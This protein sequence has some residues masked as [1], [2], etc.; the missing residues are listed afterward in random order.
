MLPV[1]AIQLNSLVEVFVRMHPLLRK[2]VLLSA[3][4]AA[5]VAGVLVAL[6]PR[7]PEYEG[8]PLSYWLVYMPGNPWP[9]PECERTDPVTRRAREIEATKAVHEIGPRCLP[10]LLQRIKAKRPWPVRAKAW[11]YGRAARLHLID[12]W[13]VVSSAIFNTATLSK[14][15]QAVAAINELGDAARPILP[16]LVALANTAHDPNVR[17]AARESLRQVAP[18]EY[19]KLRSEAVPLVDRSF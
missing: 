7:E 16:D 5:V 14:Q 4:A 17:D 6:W 9:S 10:L 3:L 13:S 19:L 2:P 12:D 8:K 11:V 18:E 15:W 1:G